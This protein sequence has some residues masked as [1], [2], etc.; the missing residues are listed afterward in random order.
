MRR[1]G[2][3]YLIAAAIGVAVDA[4]FHLHIAA[5]VALT[6]NVWVFMDREKDLQKKKGNEVD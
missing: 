3:A 1:Y 5:I 2:L 6:P 4:I